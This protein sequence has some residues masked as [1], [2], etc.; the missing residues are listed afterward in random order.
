MQRPGNNFLAGTGLP[1]QQHRQLIGQALAG[2]AQCT[3]IACIAAGQGIEIG[4]SLGGFCDAARRCADVDRALRRAQRL[5]EEFA[6]G[7]LQAADPPL[8]QAR[9]QLQAI[10]P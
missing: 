4:S 6:L 3:G 8:L 10:D 5:V 1:Q 2:H 9:Q 7:G